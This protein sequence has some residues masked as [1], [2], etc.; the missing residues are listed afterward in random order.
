MGGMLRFG[1]AVIAL[2]FRLVIVVSL[3]GYNLSTVNAA[4]HSQVSAEASKTESGQSS[5]D[6]RDHFVLSEA[7][8]HGDQHG[9]DGQKSSKE[10]CCQNY[11]GVAAL[12]CVDSTLRYLRL[13]TTHAFVDDRHQIGLSPRLHLPPNI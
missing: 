11:C 4:M 3:A 5:S 2:V 12:D 8:H 10:N 6:D 1:S 13:K 9:T 7:G